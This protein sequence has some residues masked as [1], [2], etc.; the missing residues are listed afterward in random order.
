MKEVKQLRLDAIR[1]DGGTQMRERIHQDVV[2]DYA[3]HYRDGDD[4][5]AIVVF[6]DGKENWLGDGFHRYFA[7][8]AAGFKDIRAEVRT[9]TLKD[10]IRFAWSANGSH[11][12]Q[13]SRADKR[14][15]V[16]A[17]LAD[18]ENAEA[19][20]RKIAELC[21]VA[22]TFVNNIKKE[23]AD[24]KPK[25][26]KV[27]GVKVGDVVETVPQEAA[28]KTETFPQDDGPSAE[29]MEAHRLMEEADRK[30]VE[31]MLESDDVVK[32]LHEQVKSLNHINANL[33]TRI[34]VLMREK[35]TAVDMVKDLQKQLKKATKK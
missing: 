29:E 20:N 17:A 22:H 26:E 11:G 34:N 14:R 12:L 19:S 21:A 9:G 10:A 6:F 30:L 8:E 25:A 7:S 33:Q 2:G 23:L 31:D 15:A 18:P 13:R 28:P 35:N 16:M 24:P 32:T 4:F 27:E 5:P 1:I 3:E